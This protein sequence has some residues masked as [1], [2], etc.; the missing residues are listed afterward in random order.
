MLDLDA[1]GDILVLIRS[2]RRVSV[3]LMSLARFVSSISRFS[4]CDDE[5]GARVPLSADSRRL[6]GERWWRLDADWW[7]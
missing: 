1:L 6:V 3:R 4:S 7:W 2:E 5:E